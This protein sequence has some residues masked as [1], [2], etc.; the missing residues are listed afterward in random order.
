MYFPLPLTF[1]LVISWLLAIFPLPVSAQQ[2]AASAVLNVRTFGAAGD[3]KTLDTAAINRAI[4]A[5]S[6]AGG[7]IVLVPAG[8]YR[9][10]SIHLQSRVTIQF[11]PGATVLAADPLVDPGMYDPA[12]P[13]AAEPYEDFGHS[14]WHNSLF[15]GEDLE[16]VSIVGPGLIHGMGLVKGWGNVPGSTASPIKFAVESAPRPAAVTPAGTTPPKF[17]YPSPKETLFDGVGNKSIALKNCRNVVL[18]D[19]SILHGGHFGILATGVD[20]LAIDHLTIDTNRDGMDIDACSDVHVTDCSVNSPWDDGICLKASYGL[21]IARD[22]QDVTI[23]GCYVTGGFQEGT[24]LDGTRKRFEEKH[25]PT[26]TGRIKF[27]TESNGGFRRIAITNCVFD[28][29]NGLAIESVDGGIIEDVT[30][31]NLVMHDITASPIFIRL[32]ARLRGPEGTQVGAIRRV[33]ISNVAYSGA[34]VR[35][36][37]ILSGIPGHPLEDVLISNVRGVQDGGGTEKD[38]AI[39]PP[40]KEKDYPDPRMFGAMPSWGLY[41]R[42]AVGLTVRD[43]SLRLAKPD[44]RPCVVLEDV[45]ASRF[46]DLEVPGL[47]QGR[48]VFAFRGVRDVHVRNCANTP[49]QTFNVGPAGSR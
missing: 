35:Y 30:V 15:W 8:T 19:F 47:A 32:G 40:E 49:D 28:H 29:C 44:E 12:E 39:Q 21:G 34:D 11:E 42:H 7:G 26:P 9:C 22:T 18:R 48:D 24:F 27:G 46:S 25:G 38:R 14:H 17:G 5:A 37:S 23:T 3:G 41:A 45:E 33:I 1:I 43:V 6:R 4:E 10:F 13:N 16:N 36:G 2:P 20:H 31:S